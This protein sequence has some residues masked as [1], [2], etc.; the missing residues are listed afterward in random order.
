ML[1]VC[2]CFYFWG[3]KYL[4]NTFSA[5][6]FSISINAAWLNTYGKLFLLI[7]E[8]YL[9]QL[10]SCWGGPSWWRQ[11]FNDPV[12]GVFLLHAFSVAWQLDYKNGCSYTVM[13]IYCILNQFDKSS[14]LMKCNECFFQ[15]LLPKH[16]SENLFVLKL[17]I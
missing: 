5:C 3:I 9:F 4:L 12:P 6:A 7:G 14:F 17:L 10:P 8:S 16:S 1:F 15:L 11:S 13:V 2:M